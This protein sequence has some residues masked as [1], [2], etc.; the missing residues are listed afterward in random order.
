DLARL[1]EVLNAPKL[2]RKF[3]EHWGRAN[4]HIGR[5]SIPMA[6]YVRL[7]ALKH[8]N[9]WGYERLVY[10][11]A[12][13]FHLRLFCGI[14]IDAPVPD[15][16]TIRKLTRRFGP[17]LLDDLI[18]EVIKLAVKSEAFGYGRCAAT[19]LHSRLTSAIQPTPGWPPPQLGHWREPPANC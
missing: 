2:M 11:V 4:L 16:S 17:R 5:P 9:G 1:D 19:P 3:E 12:D 7:M 15:E 10:Q 8:S 14:A 6:T 13:S 18:R